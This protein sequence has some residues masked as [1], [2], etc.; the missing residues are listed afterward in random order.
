MNEKLNKA[1]NY[2]ADSTESGYSALFTYGV[3]EIL[4]HEERREL[5]KVLRNLTVSQ[6]L[7]SFESTNNKQPVRF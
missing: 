3:K 1:L 4:N 5:A 2:I 7:T 6:N